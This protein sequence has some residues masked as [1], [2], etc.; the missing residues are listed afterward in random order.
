MQCICHCDIQYY[1]IQGDRSR[2]YSY[3]TNRRR[4][5]DSVYLTRCRRAIVV[6]CGLRNVYY[7]YDIDSTWSFVYA[8]REKITEDFASMPHG[9]HDVSTNVRFDAL[10]CTRVCTLY[11]YYVV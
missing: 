4:R 7:Y 6:D 11:I 8:S 5:P 9:R 2:A 3:T 1:N 10:Y